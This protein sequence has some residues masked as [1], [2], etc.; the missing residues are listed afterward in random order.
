[1]CLGDA[2]R[3]LDNSLQDL[4]S[5]IDTDGDQLA[6]KSPAEFEEAKALL[7]ANPVEDS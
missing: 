3:R 7:A 2:R 6:E 1:V 5:I 4:Q